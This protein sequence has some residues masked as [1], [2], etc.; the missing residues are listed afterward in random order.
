VLQLVYEFAPPNNQL[1]RTFKRRRFAVP[2]EAGELERSA[3]LA[4][5]INF[6]QLQALRRKSRW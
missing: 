4:T 1:H 2:L 3:S 6:T 5:R